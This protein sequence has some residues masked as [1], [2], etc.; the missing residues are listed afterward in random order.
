MN[1]SEKIYLILCLL[2]S[3][4]VVIGNL[5]YQKFVT[6]DF[7][8]LYSFELGAGAILY[9]VTFLITDLIAE[10]FGKKRANFC[11]K[12]SIMANFVAILIVMLINSLPATSWSKITDELFQNV[13]GFHGI[14]FICSIIACYVSQNIDVII[15]LW[16]K[17]ITNGRILWARSNFSTAISLF[18]DSTIVL[19]L[20]SLFKI[21]PSEQIWTL[22]GN[23][24]SFK[25]LFT[26]CNTPIFY[27]CYALIKFLNQEKTK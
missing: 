16:I 23:T 18:I 20:L 4:I 14:A 17:K 13:F 12:L 9:P 3:V 2:F 8:S 7:L 24:Y 5:L 19:G 26:I 21:I 27:I 11:V 25:L 15:Y 6:I 1:I 10:F 22:I